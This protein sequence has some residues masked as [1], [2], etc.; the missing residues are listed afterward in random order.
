MISLDVIQERNQASYTLCNRN[1]YPKGE[2]G[3]LE[4]EAIEGPITHQDAM[5]RL[6]L[7]CENHRH[8]R[9]PSSLY[10]SPQERD[11]G[12]G[13]AGVDMNFEL[14]GKAMGG[15]LVL[16]LGFQFTDEEGVSIY[17]HADDFSSV[18]EIPCLALVTS[19]LYFFAYV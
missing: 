9:P 11:Q 16:K 4:L 7:P 1:N 19:A 14:S 8:P 10:C 6:P 12:R 18:G 13:R 5:S 17:S 3:D 15:V 2:E